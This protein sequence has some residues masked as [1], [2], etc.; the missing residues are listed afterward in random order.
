L[1]HLPLR[2]G[3]VAEHVAVEAFARFAAGRIALGGTAKSARPLC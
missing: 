3:M 2:L 1:H